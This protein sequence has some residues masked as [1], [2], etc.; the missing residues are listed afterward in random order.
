MG[1][2]VESMAQEFVTTNTPWVHFDIMAWN[3]RNQAGRPAGGEAFGV[4]TM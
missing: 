3:T 2:V 1:A 4:R